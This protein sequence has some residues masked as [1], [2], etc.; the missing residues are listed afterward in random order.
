ML[1]GFYGASSSLV[2]VVKETLERR[3]VLSSIK[4]RIRS[5]VFAALDDKTVVKPKPSNETI[6][7]NDLIREYLEYNNYNYAAMVLRAGIEGE[8]LQGA[9]Q[10]THTIRPVLWSN[11]TDPII[12]ILPR[13]LDSTDTY[14]Q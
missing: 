6:L 9:M 14:M 10:H 1:P 2:V 11:S 13:L 3:G 4:G 5:E 8:H 12:L 7:I